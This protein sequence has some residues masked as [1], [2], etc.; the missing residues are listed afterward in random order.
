MVNRSER[1]FFHDEPGAHDHGGFDPLHGFEEQDE[2]GVLALTEKLVLQTTGFDIGSSTSHLMVSEIEL[3][4]QGFN[5]SSRFVVVRREVRYASPILLTPYSSPTSIDVDKLGGFFEKCYGE[6]GI[7]PQD[8]DTGGVII[9]GE[10]AKKENAAPILDMFAE[11]AGKFVCA[12]AGPNLEALLGAYGSGT[13]ALSRQAGGSILLVDVGGGTTKLAIVHGGQVLETMAVNVGARLV[14][15]DETGRLIRV[16]N[17][18]RRAA[19][20]IGWDPTLGELVPEDKKQPLAEVLAG[21]V[22]QLIRGEQLSP[23]AEELL[24][25]PPLQ[26][27]E[28]ITGLCFSGGVSEFIYGRE[29]RQFGDLGPWLAAAIRKEAEQSHLEMKTVEQ[30][31]R[32]TVIGSGQ[33]TVQVS[34][35][36]IFLSDPSL[37]PLR[38]VAVVPITITDPMNV[39]ATTFAIEDGLRRHDLVEGEQAVA[40]AIRWPHGPAYPVLRALADGVYNAFPRTLAKQLPLIL[41]FDNDIGGLVGSLLKRED[42]VQSPVL[43]L[44]QVDLR[45]FDFIDLGELHPMT[46]TV[47]IVIK[48]LIFA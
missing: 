6:A 39:P 32:A 22:G 2:G 36:T 16:E 48:S 27:R 44:D 18:G 24:V 14:A 46:G 25:T 37:L 31:I 13:V 21:V 47:P 19:K 40:I 45:S 4:R 12:T 42:D 15:W 38:N 35:N 29:H 5:L 8:I 3:R 33:F 34:G 10:A 17:A 1:Y 20:E 30:G 11:H 28:G 9:T 43:S 7:G 26:N 41:L 23:L